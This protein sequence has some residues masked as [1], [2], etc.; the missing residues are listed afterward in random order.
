MTDTKKH[1][2][3]LGPGG[4]Y[5]VS[6]SNSVVRTAKPANYRAMVETTRGFG[7]YPIE[8]DM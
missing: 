8:I 5:I 1:L 2:R 6:S 3:L 7:R 4:G